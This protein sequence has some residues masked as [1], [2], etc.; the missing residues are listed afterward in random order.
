MFAKLSKSEKHQ[1]NKQY[2]KVFL[3]LNNFSKYLCLQILTYLIE[4][5]IS[6]NDYSKFKSVIFIELIFT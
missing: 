4:I 3:M 6:Y 1:V 5:M 2:S